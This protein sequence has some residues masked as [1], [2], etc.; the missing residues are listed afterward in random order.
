MAQL[1]A[2]TLI[3]GRTPTTKGN[4]KHEIH[5]P[6][7]LDVFSTT[8][9]TYVDVSDS[10][11]FTPTNYY[12]YDVYFEANLAKNNTGTSAEVRLYDTT[13][14]VTKAEFSQ[15]VGPYV[16]TR[17]RSAVLSMTSC[18]LKVQLKATGTTPTAYLGAARLVLI[19]Q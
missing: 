19:P 6:M 11:G 9:T 1:K 13:N 16:Y 7:N 4:H 17:F 14:N 8:S 3:D 15:T 5:I 18:N 12:G 10:I 2:G